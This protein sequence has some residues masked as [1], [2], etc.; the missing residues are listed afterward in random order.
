VVADDTVRALAEEIIAAEPD[1]KH[2]K[3]YAR[4]RK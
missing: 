1:A 2:R 4:F 3:R